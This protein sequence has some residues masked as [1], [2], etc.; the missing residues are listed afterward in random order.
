M[1]ER[2]PPAGFRG[3]NRMKAGAALAH[4]S[5]PREKALAGVGHEYADANHGKECCNYLDHRNGPQRSA[6]TKRHGGPNSQK[7]SLRRKRFAMQLVISGNRE[8]QKGGWLPA[9]L[10]S[11]WQ[12]PGGKPI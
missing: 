6:E 7:N 11:V 8:C 10:A 9:R 4:A 5:G 1:S 3:G 12:H 2:W